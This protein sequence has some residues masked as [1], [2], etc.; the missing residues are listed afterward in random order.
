MLLKRSLKVN[1]TRRVLDDAFQNQSVAASDGRRVCPQCQ[2]VSIDRAHYNQP[3]EGGWST[4]CVTPGARPRV[5]CQVCKEKDQKPDCKKKKA[6]LGVD[7]LLDPKHKAKA[8]KNPDKKNRKSEWVP[9]E[10]VKKGKQI[11]KIKSKISP[12]D[13]IRQKAEKLKGQYKPY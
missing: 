9:Q 4:V 6:E 10:K 2:S 12:A 8:V 11:K 7:R 13:K 1:N 3:R 5:V